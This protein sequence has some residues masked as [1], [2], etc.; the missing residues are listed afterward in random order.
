MQINTKAD[1]LRTF[2][3]I[4]HHSTPQ[5]SLASDVALNL[6]NVEYDLEDDNTTG[7]S[8]ASGADAAVKFAKTIRWQYDEVNMQRL[9]IVLQSQWTTSSVQTTM[10]K[11]MLTEIEAVYEREIGAPKVVTQASVLLEG[12]KARVYQPLMTRVKCGKFRRWFMNVHFSRL[13][14]IPPQREQRASRTG[15]PI[16]QRN[17][18]LNCNA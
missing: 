11:E 15:L 6:W 7:A 3:S 1:V 9:L 4:C 12:S 2:Y 16:M 10:M 14:L 18:A 5:Y 8:S 13:L 17:D